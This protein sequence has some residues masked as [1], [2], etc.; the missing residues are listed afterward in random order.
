MPSRPRIAQIPMHTRRTRSF[1][2][3]VQVRRLKGPVPFK[4]SPSLCVPF[5]FLTFSKPHTELQLY[6]DQHPLLYKTTRLN[7]LS[8]LDTYTVSLFDTITLS[9]SQILR[10]P[11]STLTQLH[12]D[13]HSPVA[14]GFDNNVGFMEYPPNNNM[15]PTPGSSRP[16]QQH[17]FGPNP[18]AMGRYPGQDFS[19]NPYMAHP[20]GTI[21]SKFLPLYQRDLQ[22][23]DKSTATHQRT[24]TGHHQQHG[25]G[26]PMGF[27]APYWLMCPA[28]HGHGVVCPYCPSLQGPQTQPTSSQAA[29]SL[30]ANPQAVVPQQIT[31]NSAIPQGTFSLLPDPQAAIP[32]QITQQ[33]TISQAATAQAY[34]PQAAN[35]QG[36]QV[37]LPRTAYPEATVPQAA[38]APEAIPQQTTQ[39]PHYQTQAQQPLAQHQPEAPPLT[40]EQ[41]IA[42]FSPVPA[43][44]PE[45]TPR[46]GPGRK[47]KNQRFWAPQDANEKLRHRYEM[48]QAADERVDTAEEKLAKNNKPSKTAH[49]QDMLLR[50]M[51]QR[52]DRW[53]Q[54]QRVEAGLIA[55]E[56]PLPEAEAKAQRM[57]QSWAD[58]RARLQARQASLRTEHPHAVGDDGEIDLKRLGVKDRQGLQTMINWLG[59]KWFGLCDSFDTLN[60]ALYCAHG[61]SEAGCQATV[62]RI[63][64]LGLNEP[65]SLCYLPEPVQPAQPEV[66]QH[67]D[68]Q[69]EYAQDLLQ[70][71]AQQDPVP[72]ANPEEEQ[73][74]TVD[75]SL[76]ELNAFI[77]QYAPLQGQE[78]T[79]NE[80]MVLSPSSSF[81]PFDNN[82]NEIRTI[83]PSLLQRDL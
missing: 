42:A 77:A 80:Q 44:H 9:L 14:M 58:A 16:Q 61:S 18:H 76:E 66:Q 38:T 53:T 29:F 28:G 51:Q 41:K 47:K 60:Y 74:F 6:Q 19:G 4:Q 39:Q 27:Q 71:Q 33:P 79:T 21:N 68:G 82:N 13:L 70:S 69:P 55:V 11:Y 59:N 24:T 72:E 32:Q 65:W 31:Q 23:S 67:Q 1:I 54:C 43:P 37:V 8:I 5:P 64:E 10:S 26:M 17:Q 63:H 2:L 83:D 75:G 73:E 56:L 52:E 46:P 35:P 45:P 12:R 22:G 50:N 15:A 62:T 49:L 34:F 7:T 78:L 40:F 81:S 36:S 57:H 20:Q 30:L 3:S 25:S 48:L